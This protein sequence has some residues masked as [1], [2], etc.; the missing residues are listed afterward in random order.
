MNSAAKKPQTTIWTDGSNPPTFYANVI[1]VGSTPYDVTLLL[2]EMQNATETQIT[3]TPRAKIILT[4]ELA[5]NLGRL[6]DAIV[7]AYIDG[8]G[9]LRAAGQSS[10]EELKRKLID[11]A[12]KLEG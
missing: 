2:G 10:V 1:G 9:P 11:A 4:P 12:V 8:N 6:L 3:A 5:A 7:L